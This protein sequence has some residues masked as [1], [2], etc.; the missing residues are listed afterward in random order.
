MQAMLQ[1]KKLG[2]EQLRGL[3]RDDE[4][5]AGTGN[6]AGKTGQGSEPR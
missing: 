2:I 4:A 6:E 1:M 3:M 5:S